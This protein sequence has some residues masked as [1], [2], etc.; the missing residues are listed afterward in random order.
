MC[1]FTVT[2]NEWPVVSR[3]QVP[4]VPFCCGQAH[5]P[6]PISA[7]HSSVAAQVWGAASRQGSPGAV[8]GAAA[9]GL[10][11]LAQHDGLHSL[12]T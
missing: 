9:A 7:C 11:P 3:P 2:T 10:G 8:L 4:S 1:T 5:T 6:V 12:L